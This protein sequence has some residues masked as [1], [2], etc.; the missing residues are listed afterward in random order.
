MQI[1]RDVAVDVAEALV[2]GIGEGAGE[3]R[4]IA[5]RTNGVSGAPSTSSRTSLIHSRRGPTCPSRPRSAA[6]SICRSCRAADRSARECPR[7]PARPSSAATRLARRVFRP[8]QQLAGG[9]RHA[10]AAGEELGLDH[11]DAQAVADEPCRDL[12]RRQM[13]GRRN[14]S[15]VSRAGT[16]SSAPWRCSIAKAKQADDDAAVQR[17]RVPRPVRDRVG[18][19]VSRSW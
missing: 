9:A 12:D 6:W 16:K 11:P 17:V 7:A 2:A 14:M 5:T 3:I 13:L 4:A 19:K 8:A 10:G 18:M 15:T 1:Q